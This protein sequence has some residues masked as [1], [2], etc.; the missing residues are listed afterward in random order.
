MSLKRFLSVFFILGSLF[1]SCMGC[2][3]CFASNGISVS[4]SSKYLDK[5]NGFFKDCGEKVGIDNAKIAKGLG[6]CT[7]AVATVSSFIVIYKIMKGIYFLLGG[8][9]GIAKIISSLCRVF[10]GV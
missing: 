8:K 6:W 2:S 1:F 9:E 7:S 10:V 3:E 5:M 4:S